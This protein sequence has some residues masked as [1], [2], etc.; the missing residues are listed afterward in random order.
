MTTN[1]P[2]LIRAT[3]TLSA[4]VLIWASQVRRL[5]QAMHQSFWNKNHWLLMRSLRVNK[6]LIWRMSAMFIASSSTENLPG[7]RNSLIIRLQT[8][9]LSRDTIRFRFCDLSWIHWSAAAAFT[10]LSSIKWSMRVISRRRSVRVTLWWLSF[11]L[12][13]ASWILWLKSYK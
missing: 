7:S 3:T 6:T 2:I 13:I 10:T 1:W 5:I 8:I 9:A 12:T 4:V 11:T